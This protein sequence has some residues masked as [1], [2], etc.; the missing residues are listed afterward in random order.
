[1]ARQQGIALSFAF[2]V[3]VD[4]QPKKEN[5]EQIKHNLRYIDWRNPRNNVFYVTAEFEVE[6]TGSHETR[7]PDIVCFVN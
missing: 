7:R 5:P 4:H 1:M 2:A 3:Q 6:R